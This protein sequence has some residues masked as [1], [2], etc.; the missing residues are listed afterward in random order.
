MSIKFKEVYGYK[1]C[2]SVIISITSSCNRFGII[3]VT[4]LERYLVLV[5][6]RGRQ[7]NCLRFINSCF[8]LSTSN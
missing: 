5:H 1:R 4:E 3:M 7:K 8:N 2:S 6:L